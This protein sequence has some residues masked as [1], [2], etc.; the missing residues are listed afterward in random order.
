P[1]HALPRVNAEEARSVASGEPLEIDYRIRR[2]DGAWMWSH[3]EATAV[4]DEDGLPICLQ[5]MMFDITK[6]RAEE[7]RLISLDRLKNTLLHTL[8]HDL[9]AP[10]TAILAP[11]SPRER[12]GDQR[13]DDVR[14]H[15]LRT[16]VERSKGMNALLTDL[17][18]LDRLD[19]GIVG[20]RRYPLD[21]H[22]LIRHLLA[23]T[24]VLGERTVEL[25]AGECRANVD[26]PKVERI[27][28]NLLA[29]ADLHTPDGT[30]IWIRCWR[31]GDAAVIAV[32]DDGP[33]VPAEL[34]DKIFEAFY[35][36]P[37]SVHKPGSGI[38]LS[39]VARFAEMHGGRAAVQGVAGGGAAFRVLPPARSG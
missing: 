25:E 5:G 7:E 27:L 2:A 16:L 12:L 28:E 4:R 1:P 6:R 18:D 19:S 35:R 3:D 21:L 38:G 9:K 22:R 13:D 8:S 10:L 14:Q 31:E 24:K 15:M 20:P 32:D 39:L 11:A 26:Q 33:G 34:R 17:L 23:K 37:D 36:G 29:N 30:R